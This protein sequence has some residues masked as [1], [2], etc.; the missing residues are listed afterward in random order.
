MELVLI[1]TF[2]ES[3]NGQTVSLPLPN[4]WR[5]KANGLEI[6]HVPLNLYSDD[7]SGNVS[8]KWNKH[9]SFLATLAGLPPD[10]TNQEYHMHFLATSNSASALELADALVD[11]LK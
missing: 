3:E 11:E 9:M 1:S 10:L 6:K 4:P 7:T 5:K 8:K 2:L